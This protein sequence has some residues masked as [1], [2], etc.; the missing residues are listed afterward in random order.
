[1]KFQIEFTPGSVKDIEHFKKNEQKIILSGIRRY[2]SEDADVETKRKK[3]LRPNLL[4]TRELKIGDLRVFYDI[5]EYNLVKVTVVGFK[6]HNELF[7]RGK[8]VE[9]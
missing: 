1:M 7:V 6:V 9:L 4:A 8:R 2:L 5:V 3:V